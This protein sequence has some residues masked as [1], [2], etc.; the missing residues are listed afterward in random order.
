[1]HAFPLRL[2]CNVDDE[3]LYDAWV[4]A[5]QIFSMLRTSF[6]FVSG[7]GIW[8]Q[9]V[10]SSCELD[11]SIESFEN[12]EEY[13]E[14]LRLFLVAIKPSDEVAFKRPPFRLRMFRA[15]SSI[16]S[17]LVLVMHHALYDGLSVAK[18]LETVQNIYHGHQ[19]LKGPQFV[20]LLRQLMAQEQNGTS[21]W[22]ERLRNF[23]RVEL[24]KDVTSHNPRVSHGTSHVMIVNP[25][26]VDKV[27]RTV[28]VTAQC[29]GQAALAKLIALMSLSVDVV[30]GHVVSGRSLPGA[31]DVIGPV[32]VSSV[33]RLRLLAN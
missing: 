27:C 13:E 6:H 32:L 9:A 4:Q 33:S 28:A 20:D 1:M 30:F 8:A 10:H 18:L 22:V 26:L 14:N 21:F 25:V 12:I 17:R 24:P 19:I 5:M 2:T 3:R 16:D 7:P 11:W 23:H 29:L 31:E 15:S